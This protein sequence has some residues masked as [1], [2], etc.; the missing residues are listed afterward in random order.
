[1]NIIEAKKKD[2]KARTII[3]ALLLFFAALLFAAVLFLENTNTQKQQ[4][5]LKDSIEN[6][7]RSITLA[8]RDLTSPELIESY[9]SEADI[10]KDEDTFIEFRQEL[11]TLAKN[12]GADYIYILKYVD[13][14]CMFIMDTDEEDESVFIPYEPAAVHEEAFAGKIAS[15]V[16]NVE[17]EYGSYNTAA[18]PIMHNGQ[19]IGIISVDIEDHYIEESINQAN[20]VFIALVAVISVILIAMISLIVFLMYRVN[21]MQ[22]QL[23]ILAHH[24]TVTGLPNRQYLL[25]VLDE[26]MKHK[27]SFA[28]IFIDLD[29]FKTINDTA[30]HDTGDEVLK[31]VGKYLDHTKKNVTAFRPSAG[32]LNIA[33]RVGGD[34]FIQV[35]DHIETVEQAKKLATDLLEGFQG[36]EFAHYREKYGLGMSIGVALYPEHTNNYHILI[37]YADIAMYHAKHGGKNAY[38]IYEETMAPKDE[39]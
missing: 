30:G 22:E 17:D 20:Q 33:A 29:N 7:L 9:D 31:M 34:E 10:H 2:H 25:D 36:S 37:K 16:M 24:D 18:A 23:R 39:K 15:G 1:M 5:L 4:E 21:R 19:I 27:K 13:G 14:E 26:K 28:L 3:I 8:A 38:R 12:T 35:V 6:Q 32:H 11:R